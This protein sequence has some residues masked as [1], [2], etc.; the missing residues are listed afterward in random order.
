MRFRA[1]WLVSIAVLCL[2][3]ILLI[4]G[5]WQLA[6]LE[7]KNK[8]LAQLEARA[9]LKAVDYISQKN[10]F[11]ANDAFTRVRLVGKFDFANQQ[12]LLRRHVDGR[13]GWHVLTPLILNEQAGVLLVNRGW[14]SFEQQDSA[15]EFEKTNKGEAVVEGLLHMPRRAPRWLMPSDQ[16]EKK[17]WYRED[18]QAIAESIASGSANYSSGGAVENTSTKI[19]TRWVVIADK[20][21]DENLQG[22]SPQESQQESPQARQWKKSV[23]NAHASYA[24]TWFL[25][26][27]SLLVIFLIANTEIS[28]QKS[29]SKSKVLKNK[30]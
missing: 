6:R 25:L 23:R 14:I 28:Q 10:K 8:L 26:S 18:L 22:E 27:L 17:L 5:F 12:L 30:T 19:E 15:V 16:P 2:F 21:P 29:D 20:N 3:A 4:L 1:R 7:W 9:E 24:A 11:G 13:P